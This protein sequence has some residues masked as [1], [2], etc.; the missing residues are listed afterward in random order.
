MF[1]LETNNSCDL[2]LSKEMHEIFKEHENIKRKQRL[3]Y[4][5]K[6]YSTGLVI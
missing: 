5:L 6:P 2:S 3:E 1:N 4:M